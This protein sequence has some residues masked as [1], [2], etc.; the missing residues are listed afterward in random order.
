MEIHDVIE[1]INRI[2]ETIYGGRELKNTAF[3]HTP[4]QKK[5]KKK[6]KKKYDLF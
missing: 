6:K 4:R 3:L 1:N 2:I 5:R